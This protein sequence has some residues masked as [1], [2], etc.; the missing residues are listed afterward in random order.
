MIDSV[1][2][3]I[4]ERK[5]AEEALRQARD[6]L[7]LRV[8]ERTAEL[9]RSNALLKREIAER[10]RA[11]KECRN[12]N[13][14][15]NSFVHV[16]S[17]DLK[18]PITCIQGFSSRLVKKFD[19]KLDA[20]ARRYV[21]QIQAGARRMETLVSDLLELSRIGSLTC[22][23]KNVPSFQIVRSVVTSLENRL[24]EKGIELVLS[25]N[26]P[27]ICCDE[28]RMHQVF[29]NLLV[30]AIKFMGPRQNPKI[31]V[32]CMETGDFYQ[33]YVKDNGIGIDPKH[34][35][36]IFEMFCRLNEIRDGEGTGLGLAIVERIVNSCGGSIWVESEKGEGAT[37]HFTVPKRPST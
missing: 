7:E 10:E 18:N 32:G 3:E 11:E 14:E 23:F 35:Q 33:F 4:D 17:H 34:H 5:R 12:V 29:E 24:Q 28:E 37:F 26:F 1:S 13:E 36:K 9:T 21:E 2:R 30:N 20:D 15:L 25:G 27:T 8:E 16:V 22:S 6:D 31:E 19:D